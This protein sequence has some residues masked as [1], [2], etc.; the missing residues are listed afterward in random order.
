[1]KTRLVSFGRNCVILSLLVILAL[2]GR[3]PA[4]AQGQRGAAA[5]AT[6][7][8]PGALMF[9]ENVGQFP[10][11][12]RFQVRGA[13]LTL[14]LAEDAIWLAVRERGAE[15][16]AG[17]NLRLSFPGGNLHPRL[18]PFDPLATQVSFLTGDDPAGWRAG[19]PAWGGV[20]YVDLYPGIDLELSGA[21]GRLAARLV[22]RP[23]ADL[24]AVRLRVEGAEAV[25]RE[26]DVLRLGTTAGDVPWPLLR[27]A[28][29][30]GKA[31]VQALGSQRFEV[32]EPF[33][34]A[35]DLK[36]P[37]ATS[38][39]PSIP[40]DNPTD[41]RYGTFLGGSESDDGG[42]LA[43]DG[44]GAAYVT[45][46]TFSP[47]FPATTGAFDP[48]LGA[49]GDAFVAKLSPDG[50][51]LV[52][53][54]FLGGD[55]WERGNAIVVDGTGTV[56]L[57]GA[58]RSAD[59]PTTAGAFDTTYN[60]YTDAFVAKLS[61]DGRT[62][63]YGTF[64]GGSSTW[65]DVGT[66]I[67]VDGEGAAYVTGYTGSADFPTTEGAFDPAINGGDDAFV[68]KLNMAGSALA[69][70]T[71]LG[72]SGF[73]TGSGIAV[74]GG[75]AAIVTGYTESANWPATPDA[76]D[77]SPNGNGDAFVARLA[78]DGSD[79]DYGTFL[80][81]SDEDRADALSVGGDG[82]ATVT[83]ATQ[84][85]DFPA[86]PG[87]FDTSY[88]GGGD[89]MVARLAADGAD[90]VY[91]TFVG[92][93][94][95]DW[96]KGIAVDGEGAAYLTGGTMSPDFPTTAAAFD[97]SYNGG[98]AYSGDALVAKLKPD[99]SALVNATFLG[100][101]DDDSGQAI[102]VDGEGAATI[103]GSTLSAGFPT[104][105]GA[106]DRSY[107]GGGPYGGDALVAKLAM[108][109]TYAISGRVTG[110]GDLGIQGVVVSAGA[111][112]PAVTDANGEYAI[113]G[114]LSG[115]YTLTPLPICYSFEP[116]TRTVTVPPDATGQDFQAEP[117][118]CSR[119]YLPVVVRNP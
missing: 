109:P 47:D 35:E 55:G 27:A 116:V 62:L 3:Q 72:G 65:W 58:T 63:V 14:W 89:A 59:F 9:L 83:G 69:Y 108:T 7:G 73:D 77:P 61:P 41:L 45:G 46:S 28:G 6:N 32:A 36:R 26:G 106:F 103:T 39:E 40:G 10:E 51:T 66:G 74:D 19:V 81:G 67:A 119:V 48:S 115:T 112:S 118:A 94:A 76:F 99:G 98:G 11:D 97:R 95:K 33:V 1:M 53:A 88:N 21:Q 15:G 2:S 20:R 30:S 93:S 25:T 91:A 64:L 87:A 105:A 29:S 101:G 117:A 102:A 79:L 111:G 38:P 50:S 56:Y 23:G 84:S 12:A 57:T 90:L 17:A 42:G 82:T 44:S 18:Q 110:A 31:T 104:T 49:G 34:R 52:Y 78:A 24:G 92:G 86:T 71:F 75:G 114:V 5:P 85:A 4:T 60:G 37:P 113:T 16:A 22:A 13:S 68:T 70:S 8:P 43:V 80:G 107:N 54:T 96:A 100:G